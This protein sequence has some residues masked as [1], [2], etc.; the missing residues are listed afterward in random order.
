MLPYNAALS[1]GK[2]RKLQR[3]ES[4]ELGR[5]WKNSS[6]FFLVNAQTN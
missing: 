5:G 1:S 6:S 3:I 4:D 2:R